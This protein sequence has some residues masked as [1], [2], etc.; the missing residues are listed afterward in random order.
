MTVSVKP[1][2]I[3]RN[4]SPETIEEYLSE[5]GYKIVGFRIVK[6]GDTILFY[7]GGDLAVGSAKVEYAG[8]PRFILDRK[9][10]THLMDYWE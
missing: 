8:Y 5:N 1:S 10:S 3:Y 2:E 9:D 7:S 4:I 6:E